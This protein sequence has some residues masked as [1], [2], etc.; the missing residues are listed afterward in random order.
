MQRQVLEPRKR[1]EIPCSALL[2]QKSDFKCSI[3]NLTAAAQTERVQ[4]EETT[5]QET[6]NCVL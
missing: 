5:T 2:E 1:S 3:V 6:M 4:K